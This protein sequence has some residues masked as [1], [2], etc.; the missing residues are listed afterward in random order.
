[1]TEAAP[2]EEALTIFGSEQTMLPEELAKMGLGEQVEVQEIPGVT[3]SWKPVNKG[4]F[5]LGRVVDVRENLGKFGSTAVV[6]HTAVPG[7]FRTVWLGADLK[8]KMRNALGKVYS[9]HFDGMMELA[10]RQP[11]KV[12]RVYEVM[13][14]VEQVPS[15]ARQISGQ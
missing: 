6:F 5:L 2:N 14:K 11:M 3:P 15:D 13:P 1:M 12:Y 4:D 8:V 10:G 7:G 9:I